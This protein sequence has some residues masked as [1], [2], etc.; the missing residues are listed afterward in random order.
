VSTAENWRFCL[1]VDNQDGF[2]ARDSKAIPLLQN[3]RP[4][5]ARQRE[6][7]ILRQEIRKRPIVP[8]IML[9]P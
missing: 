7:D 8:S 3:L 5:G 2:F 9:S 1:N 6:S 4:S